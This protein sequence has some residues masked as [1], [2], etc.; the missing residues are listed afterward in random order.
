MVIP[1]IY[2]RFGEVLGPWN[3]THVFTSVYR[4]TFVVAPISLTRVDT[5]EKIVKK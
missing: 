5:K 2:P 3:G 1:R 4:V